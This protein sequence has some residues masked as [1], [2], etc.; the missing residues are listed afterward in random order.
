MVPTEIEP[1]SILE[2]EKIISSHKSEIAAESYMQRIPNR[3]NIQGFIKI[4]LISIVLSFRHR[5]YSIL[6]ALRN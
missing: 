1:S 5:Y 6:Q 4:Y 2:L 3:G